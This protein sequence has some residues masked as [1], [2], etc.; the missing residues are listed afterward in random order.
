MLDPESGS[1]VPGRMVSSLGRIKSK[2]GNVHR[3][4]LSKIGYYGTKIS[5][6]PLPMNKLVHRLVAFTFLGPPPT[7]Q[8]WQVNHKDGDKTNNGIKNLEYVT[9]SENIIHRFAL[10]RS[11]SKKTC[12]NRKPVW[13][14]RFGTNHEWMWHPSMAHAAGA[15]NLH[16]SNIS[17]CCRSLLRQTGGFEFCFADGDVRPKVLP[18]EDW[19]KVD[20]TALLTEKSMRLSQS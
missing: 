5:L 16:S 3:G 6:E 18:G 1:E 17:A 2:S 20:L 10:A 14:R 8:H 7:Q 11:Q 13:S 9:P 12:G 4:H 15:L 19:R